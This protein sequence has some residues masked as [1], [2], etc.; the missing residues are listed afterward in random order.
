M[1]K[2][3]FI[4]SAGYHNCEFSRMSD[5]V[6]TLGG[7]KVE[8]TSGFTTHRLNGEQLGDFSDYDTVYRILDDAVQYSNDGSIYIEPPKPEPTPEPEPV[9]DHDPAPSLEERITD[10][11]IAVCELAEKA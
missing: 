1:I 3:K 11:E 4:N 10:L 9:P 7:C 5:H 2:I 8:N 6:V